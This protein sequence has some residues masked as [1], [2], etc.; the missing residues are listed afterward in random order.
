MRPHISLRDGFKLMPINSRT[1]SDDP[2]SKTAN[3]GRAYIAF[4]QLLNT[5][6]TT[7]SSDRDTQKAASLATWLASN[8]EPEV[9]R[10]FFTIYVV[11]GPGPFVEYFLSRLRAM[12][13]R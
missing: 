6:G 4:T 9:L 13:N 1:S 8:L 5:R 10:C 3:F 12:T 7:T 11:W 2:V